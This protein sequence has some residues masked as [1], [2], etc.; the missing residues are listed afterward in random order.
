MT[1]REAI[2]AMLDGAKCRHDDLALGVWV[3]FKDDV[4]K[5]VCGTVDSQVANGAFCRSWNWSVRPEAPVE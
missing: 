5:Y 4:F 3:G 1:N 2:L